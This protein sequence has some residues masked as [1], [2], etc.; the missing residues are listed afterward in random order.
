MTAWP[1]TRMSSLEVFSA[2]EMAFRKKCLKNRIKTV[3]PLLLLILA[4]ESFDASGS[5]DEL[6]LAGIKWVAFRADFQVDLSFRRPCLES[7]ATGAPD[8]RLDV[9]GMDIGLH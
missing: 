1:P 4:L 6:L 9:I 2:Q 8:N 7:L 3:S 5:V